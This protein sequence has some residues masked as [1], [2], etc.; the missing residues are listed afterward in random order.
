MNISPLDI[1]KH[2]F[3]KTLRG[4]DPD[5]V[6]TFLDMMSIEFENIIRENAMLNEKVSN[7]HEQLKKY[8]D[9]ESTLQETLLSAQRA[10]ED[11]IKNA[12]KQAEVII[13]EAEVK[14][15]SIIEEG[16]KKLSNLNS[17]F[18]EIKIQKDTYLVKLKALVNA[19]LE[20][21]EKVSFSE[22]DTLEKMS[23]VAG[24]EIDNAFHTKKQES[25]APRLKDFLND[26]DSAPGENFESE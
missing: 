21:L 7:Y 8:H 13:R 12:K 4:F 1:R 23:S 22:E 6:L 17:I 11:T 15:A 19:Q 24:D 18:T 26:K 9:I 5:E 16:R 2:E 25:T 3:R 20:I 10:R 14:A